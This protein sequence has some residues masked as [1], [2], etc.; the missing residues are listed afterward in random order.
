MVSITHPL[1]AAAVA[2]AVACTE[3][4]NSLQRQSA[5]RL[6]AWPSHEDF[7]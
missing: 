5:M 4:S 7:K 2:A 1:V 3:I 6:R